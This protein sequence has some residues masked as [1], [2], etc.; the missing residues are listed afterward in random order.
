ML[1]ISSI[2]AAASCRDIAFWDLISRVC[3]ANSGKW[4]LLW[5]RFFLK[6]FHLMPFQLILYAFVSLCLCCQQRGQLINSFW[7]N[8]IQHQTT[9]GLLNTSQTF[10]FRFQGG[11]LFSIRADILH[12]IFKTIL[13]VAVQNQNNSFF[14]TL[15]IDCIKYIY[16]KYTV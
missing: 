10:Q 2:T 5:P 12:L 1:D 16:A 3:K 6:S 4:L 15:Q 13:C 9:P 14:I 11:G 8:V 7:N